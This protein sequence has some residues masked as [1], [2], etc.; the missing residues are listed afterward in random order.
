[1]H[2]SFRHGVGRKCFKELVF[3][4][5][6]GLAEPLPLNPS[7]PP[8]QGGGDSSSSQAPGGLS[9]PA[10]TQTLLGPPHS[11]QGMRSLCARELGGAPLQAGYTRIVPRAGR[12]ASLSWGYD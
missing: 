11:P 5:S 7:P 12:T 6:R 3:H 10:S 2:H 4:T 9:S 8:K 1:M